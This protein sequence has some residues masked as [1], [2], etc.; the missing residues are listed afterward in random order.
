MA[1]WIAFVPHLYI[2]LNL[3]DYFFINLTLA[4]NIILLKNETLIKKNWIWNL[5]R[6]FWFL[7][8]EA[9]VC[10]KRLQERCSTVNIAKF[11]RT[12]FFNRTSPV[13]ASAVLLKN[14]K[15]TICFDLYQW[16]NTLLHNVVKWSGTL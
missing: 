13:A 2:N 4:K 16:F 9:A 11:L 14:L 5:S 7:V 3:L 10:K 1:V 8:I 15:N 6:L 12:P